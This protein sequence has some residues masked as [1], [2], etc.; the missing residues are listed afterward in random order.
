MRAVAQAAQDIIN[1]QQ[2]TVSSFGSCIKIA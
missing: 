1:L 2:E